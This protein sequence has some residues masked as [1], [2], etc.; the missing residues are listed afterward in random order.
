MKEPDELVLPGKSKHFDDN[1]EASDPGRFNLSN[2]KFRLFFLDLY[3][4][5]GGFLGFGSHYEYDVEASKQ[6]HQVDMR[7]AIAEYMANGL[8]D[9]AM[10]VSEEPL[11]IATYSYDAD[12]AVMLSF[13]QYFRKQ[14]KLTKGQ[15]MLS[16]NTFSMGE[17]F[18]GDLTLG[19][20]MEGVFDNIYP[21]IVLFLSNNEDR[22][23]K[24]IASI[25]EERWKHFEVRIEDYLKQN[26][27]K[28]ARSGKPGFS[29][30]PARIGEGVLQKK[31]R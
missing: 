25:P 4:K 18:A 8:C 28:V 30:T 13:N 11:R 16:V 31:M 3:K 2:A 22:I 27:D 19:E 24:K 20:K 6:K 5:K 10:V 1:S 12:S 14:Y 9:M 7:L 17:G 21:L 15:R 29:G 23:I 26:G